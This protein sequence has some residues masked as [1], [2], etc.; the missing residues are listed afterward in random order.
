MMTALRVAEE[1]LMVKNIAAALVSILVCLG[2]MKLGLRLYD[3]ANGRSFFTTAEIVP[4]RI[5]GIQPDRSKGGELSIV[6]QH[7]KR[8]PFIKPENTIDIVT[9]GGSTSVNTAI[10]RQYGFS[11]VS[12]LQYGLNARFDDY[13]FEVINVANEAYATPHSLTLLAFDVISW[14]PDIVIMLHYVND[15][16]ASFFPDFVPDY[17]NEYA[18]SYYNMS[19]LRYS[20]VSLRVCRMIRSRIGRSGL[21]T[22]QP[23]R[24]SFGTEPSPNVQDVFARN[25]RSFA[26]LAKSQGI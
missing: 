22:Y 10:Y 7:G 18:K 15:L 9:F 13:E 17:A 2:L 21:L 24:K 11:Y 19:W 8:F 14:K 4:F 3:V 1:L 12:L 5:F 6:A 26:T 20:C 16:H 25:F 23:R